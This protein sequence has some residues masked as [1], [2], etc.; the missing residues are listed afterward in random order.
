MLFHA[1]RLDARLDGRGS[2]L[3][4]EEQDRGKWD[5]ELIRRA[6]QFLNESAEGALVSPFHL[7]A[8]I[9]YLHCTAPSYAET[10][11][12]A[13]LRLYD[14]LLTLHR[15]PVYLL[16][17]AI[18][19]A[20]IDGPQAGIRALE[21]AGLDPALRHYHLFDATLGEFYRRAGDWPRAR[22]HLEAARRKTNSPFDR[23]LLDR[24]LAQCGNPEDDLPNG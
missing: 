21:E 7:E 9:A 11:W 5:Q 10:D 18:V 1:A 6:R 16:N 15:S 12:P 2:L 22:R 17:R 19:V 14:A 13:I 3:L 24:R 20:Q 8:G 23:E 4:M